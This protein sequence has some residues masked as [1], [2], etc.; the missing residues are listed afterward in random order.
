MQQW[1]EPV[2]VDYDRQQE[3]EEQNMLTRMRRKKASTD[4]KRPP[5]DRQVAYLEFKALP[6]AQQF[7]AEI[8]ES[9]QTL[10]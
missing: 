4:E 10:K 8:V 5:T 7:E 9:R 2:E 3:E 6:E 1:E